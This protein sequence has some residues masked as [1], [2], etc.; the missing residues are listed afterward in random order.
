MAR[1]WK[2][3]HACLE[4]EG[5]FAS[6]VACPTE[7]K[8]VIVELSGRRGSPGRSRRRRLSR[9]NTATMLAQ[10]EQ[11]AS[12]SSAAR[13]GRTSGCCRRAVPAMRSTSRCGI[14]K[15]SAAAS[16]PGSCR[17][18]RCASDLHHRDDRH[19]QPRRVRGTRAPARELRVDQDQGECKAPHRVRARRQPRCPART[20]GRG[21]QPG[22]G[23]GTA[24][25]NCPGARGAWGRSAR[26]ACS[27]RCG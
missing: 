14:L 10:I 9:R 13:A 24:R 23:R 15:P 16:A 4:A 11:C 19:S 6:P 17:I 20:T 1:D 3:R 22:L 2:S 26:T 7:G 18:A 5:A 12:R 21:C 27:H 8:V 25:G